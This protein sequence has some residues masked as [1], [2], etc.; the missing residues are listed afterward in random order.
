MLRNEITNNCL[1]NHDLYETNGPTYVLV[2][3]VGLSNYYD[4]NI[5]V[6]FVQIGYIFLG[7]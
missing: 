6:I 3:A 7:K 1:T 2:I 5:Q 4:K